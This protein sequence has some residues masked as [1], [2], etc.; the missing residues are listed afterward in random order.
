MTLE[1]VSAGSLLLHISARATCGRSCFDRAAALLTLIA[2]SFAEDCRE[3]IGTVTRRN[4]DCVVVTG[5]AK[6]A[7][8][9]EAGGGA[10]A[11]P[12][13]GAT[14]IMSAARYVHCC[15]IAG[16]YMTEILP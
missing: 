4:G 7:P 15:N 13:Y 3:L 2:R 12:A 6:L 1:T 11:P 16:N 5:S 14:F 9:F 8:S 10:D